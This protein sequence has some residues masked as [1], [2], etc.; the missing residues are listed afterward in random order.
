VPLARLNLEIK[1]EKPV[2]AITPGQTVAIYD[3]DVLLGGGTI[4]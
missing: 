3:K 1:F 2:R 4:S